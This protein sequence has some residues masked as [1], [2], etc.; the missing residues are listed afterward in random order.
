MAQSHLYN[1]PKGG[2]KELKHETNRKKRSHTKQAS[3]LSYEAKI[4]VKVS[5]KLILYYGMKNS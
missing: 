4:K 2:L 3:L 1:Q 5:L